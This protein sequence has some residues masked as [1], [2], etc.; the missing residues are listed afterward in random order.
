MS[1]L[2]DIEQ[3]IL[4]GKRINE[5]ESLTLFQQGNLYDLGFLADFIRKKKHP[6]PI[7]TYVIDRNINYSNICV[8][9]CLFCAFYREKNHPEAYIL[10]EKDISEKIT[11]L[12]NKTVFRY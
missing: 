2:Q 9:G 4:N 12:Y 7:V 10:S 5:T 11:E 6:D 3:K 1:S 8:S